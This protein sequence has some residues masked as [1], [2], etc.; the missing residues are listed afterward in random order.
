[1]KPSAIDPRERVLARCASLVSGA[2]PR[3]VEVDVSSLLVRLLLFEE[4]V[5]QSIRLMEFPELVR[6]VGIESTMRLLRSRAIRISMMP[7][8]IGQTGQAGVLK[9]RQTKGVLPLLSYSFDAVSTADYRGD[10]KKCLQDVRT[11][12]EEFVTKKQAKRLEVEVSNCIAHPA[13]IGA[14]GIEALSQLKADLVSG[15]PVITEAIQH[16]LAM[17]LGVPPPKFEFSLEQLDKTDFRANTNIPDVTKLS[18]EEAHQA[19]QRG[20]L[21]L[22]GLYIRFAQMRALD[23]VAAFHEDDI[24]LLDRKLDYLVSQVNP[25]AQETRFKRVVSIVGLPDFT[26]PEDVNVAKLLEVRDSEPCREF[27]HWLRTLDQAS[28]REIEDM[29]HPVRD[30]LGMAIRHPAGKAVRLATT[31]AVGL[32]PGFGVPAS[33]ALGAIDTFLLE[34]LLPEPGP[35][36]FLA[37]NYRSIFDTSSE[38]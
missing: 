38:T 14:I 15:G 4:Q 24:R 9:S 17:K 3:A 16:A 1:V 7:L 5:V 29:L 31:G 11:R 33:A 25:A 34:R 6:R 13:D 10:I 2:G 19:I 23:S 22:G 20:L 35:T 28:D 21:A 18:V 32:I 27:R 30:L 37:L 12:C 36:A 8:S 26:P